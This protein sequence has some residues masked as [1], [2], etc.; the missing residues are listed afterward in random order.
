MNMQEGISVSDDTLPGRFLNEKRFSDP[1]NR[2]VHLNWMLRRYY[3]YR[4][5]DRNGIPTAGT[6]RKLEIL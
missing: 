1:K 4:G 5:Y 6:L 3:R 2:K